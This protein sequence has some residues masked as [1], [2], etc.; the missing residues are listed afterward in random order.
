[1]NKMIIP[2]RCMLFFSLILF[3]F[4]SIAGQEISQKGVASPS[5]ETGSI[6]IAELRQQA[7]KNAMD[8]AILQV[9]GAQISSERG[10][11]T[12]AKESIVVRNGHQLNTTSEQSRFNTAIKTRT[13]GHA[14][15]VR[16]TKEWLDGRLYH[17]EAI[18]NVDTPEEL[19][20]QKN[21]GYYW[22]KAGRPTLGF[23][24][25]QEVNGQ[26]EDGSNCNTLRFLQ[27]N[28]SRNDLAA[29]DSYQDSRYLIKAHQNVTHHL[30]EMGTVTLNCRLSFQII[31]QVKGEKIAEYRKAN[32]PQAGFSTEQATDDCLKKIAP[33]VSE[34]LVRIIAKT[35]NDQWN[36]GIRYTIIIEHVSGTYI[37]GITEILNNLF[38]VTNTFPPKYNN[39]TY[40]QE[41]KYKGSGGELFQ[42][43]QDAFGDENWTVDVHHIDEQT[44]RLDWTTSP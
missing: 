36:N 29:K 22:N 20:A 35:M 9:T 39:G 25:Q 32:G 37:S 38:Q 16:I 33:D 2:V 27:E 40:I 13:D 34:H 42:A 28:L 8:L 4:E 26:I 21:A 43:I 12:R 17:V 19:L 30:S 3:S 10:G 11:A 14:K 41:V 1:M 7:I 15:L 44:L 5:S 18:F 23:S 31:D 6:D 24:F